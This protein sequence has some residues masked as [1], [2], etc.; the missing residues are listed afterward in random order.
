MYVKIT[1]LN[2]YKK[3]QNPI[4]IWAEMM[5]KHCLKEDIEMDI[6]IGKVSFCLLLGKCKYKCQWN[7]TSYLLNFVLFKKYRKQPVLT[8]ILCE[9]ITHS[10]WI[11]MIL[12][13]PLWK[14]IW[15]FSKNKKKNRMPINSSDSTLASI[16]RQRNFYLKGHTHIYVHCSVMYNNQYMKTM[17]IANI[18]WVDK[19]LWYSSSVDIV[20]I[21][22]D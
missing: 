14:T 18:E 2:R 3:Y 10:L 22:K 13:R 12:F 9:R 8:R 1:K 21:R 15:N 16:P 17:Q 4:K 20:D 7:I 11:G 19:Q 6:S 5:N